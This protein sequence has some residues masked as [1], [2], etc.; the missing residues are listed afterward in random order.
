[1]LSVRD[2]LPESLHCGH[3]EKGAN[4]KARNFLEAKRTDSIVDNGK[5]IRQPK[6]I[7]PTLQ[8]Y[9][10]IGDRWFNLNKRRSFKAP[11]LI[12]ELQLVT[13]TAAVFCARCK[14]GN[15]PSQPTT[16]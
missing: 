11:I 10:M 16:T 8:E 6:F 13:K 7:R 1:L 2:L 9:L 5:T 12:D 14:N 3:F 4:L 15:R